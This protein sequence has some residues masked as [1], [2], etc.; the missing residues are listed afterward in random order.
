MPA[1]SQVPLLFT[2]DTST[3][4]L[5][6]ESQ[7]LRHL[8]PF[9]PSQAEIFI[10]ETNPVSLSQ[11]L[12]HFS[13]HLVILMFTVEEG[14]GETVKL[15]F[16]RGPGRCLQSSMVA[17]RTAFVFSEHHIPEKAL[18]III[19]LDDQPH[20]LR[21]EKG[22]SCFSTSPVFLEWMDIGI[23]EEP[24]DLRPAPSQS[25]KRKNRAI[26]TA[27]VKQNPL[28]FSIPPRALGPK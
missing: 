17:V 8:D 14:C 13:D 4:L 7:L 6:V 15:A 16:L 25:L 5:A 23:V 24:R 21:P 20:A 9:L 18:E 1:F 2:V 19:V 12:S 28:H 26:R 27:C 10:G 22:L 3:V 11:T